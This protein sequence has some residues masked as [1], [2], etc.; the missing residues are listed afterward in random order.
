M[1]VNQMLT[2]L[3][4]EVVIV[5]YN[6]FI[7]EMTDEFAQIVISPGPGHP[8]EYPKIFQLLEQFKSTKKILGICLGHQIIGLHFGAELKQ[9]EN[10]IHGKQS[11]NKLIS[12]SPIYNNMPDN[13]QIGRYHSWVLDKSRIPNDLEI[14]SMA[15]D[16]Q[17]MS[18]KH[19]Q[20]NIIGVQFHPESFITQCGSQLLNNWLNLI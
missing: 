12:N 16:N 14:L 2:E 9:I 5:N 15:E 10:I 20:F 19:K 7:P 4:T 18:I 6:D 11:Q 8:D 13:C 1:N 17:V 3:N